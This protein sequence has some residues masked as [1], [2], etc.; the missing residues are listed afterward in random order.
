MALYDMS[1]S[2]TLTGM[3]YLTQ[4]T[5]TGLITKAMHEQV[6]LSDDITGNQHKH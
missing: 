4:A 1:M 6:I 5:R 3:D 2:W